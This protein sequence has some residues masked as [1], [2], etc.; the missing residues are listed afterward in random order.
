MYCLLYCLLYCLFILLG[1][2]RAYSIVYCL[3]A[4]SDAQPA[5][6]LGSTTRRLFLAADATWWPLLPSFPVAQGR[7]GRQFH[8][9]ITR[10]CYSTPE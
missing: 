4:F 9:E 6:F 5:D 3:L 8:T 7:S 1:I 2:T 10:C